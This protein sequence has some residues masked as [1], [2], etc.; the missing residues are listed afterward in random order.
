VSLLAL[1]GISNAAV[2]EINMYG[3]SAEYNFWS[4]DDTLFLQGLGCA[5]GDVYKAHTSDNNNAVA[6]CAGTV[7]WPPA[8]ATNGKTGAGI[9]NA[10][11]GI[12]A[13]DTVVL[14]Y[15]SKASYDGIEAVQ[16]LDAFN[17]NVGTACAGSPHTRLMADETTATWASNTATGTA[18][19]TVNVANSDV[20]AQTFNETTWGAQN[21]PAGGTV[22][23]RTVSGLTVPAGYTNKSPLVVPFAFF[24][25]N[26]LNTG[27]FAGANSVSNLTR[28][29]ATQLFSGMVTDWS[30]LGYPAG[31]ITVCLRHAGSGTLATLDAAIM[32]GDYPL[33]QEENY[34]ASTLQ[35]VGTQP[36]T[37]FNDGTG[38]ELTCINMEPNAIGIADADKPNV[39]AGG[40]MNGYSQ[41]TFQ[42]AAA[43]H[44]NIINGVYDYWSNE[45]IYYDTP[46][47]TANWG[48]VEGK[49]VN[50]AGGLI[51]YV[52]NPANI[53]AS[54]V[55]FWA[56][57]SQLSVTKANDFQYPGR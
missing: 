28:L 3:A 40:G 57:Y 44:N 11:M 1:G 29:E 48:A 45:E 23:N 43:N 42:G 9:V 16:G 14:R 13:S 26:S 25:N 18:C 2:Y 41:I 10:A 38:T 33:M 34:A 37:Y 39:A 6:F 30:Q 7:A 5:A 54:E 27:A 50:N 52:S 12:A 56:T 51:S 46:Y 22:I 20:Q 24:V 15:S 55:N 35:W 21:G 4:N 32:R 8:P 19:K 53:P 36:I 31:A 17:T 49:I 47:L